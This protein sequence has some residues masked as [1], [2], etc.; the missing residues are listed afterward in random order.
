M[1]LQEREVME[2]GGSWVLIKAARFL[3]QG[4]SM[5]EQEE[6]KDCWET[7]SASQLRV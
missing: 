1:D 6:N 5:L 3:S 2:G 7:A 4:S